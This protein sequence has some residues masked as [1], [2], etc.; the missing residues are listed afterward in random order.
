MLCA[1]QKQESGDGINN[2]ISHQKTAW[3]LSVKSWKSLV[4]SEYKLEHDA[5]F[6]SF[7]K[8]LNYGIWRYYQYLYYNLELW[9]KKFNSTK[10][11]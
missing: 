10:R 4:I 11:K 9:L 5:I 2:N 6:T 1:W 7:I 8:N 3:L